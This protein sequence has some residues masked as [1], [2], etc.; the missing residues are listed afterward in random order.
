MATTSAAPKGLQLDQITIDPPAK[1]P[2]QPSVDP[3]TQR[4]LYAEADAR[5]AAQSGV[6]RK[7]DPHNPVDK[8]L[9]PAWFH[10]Y[11]G[12]LAEYGSG[13][14]HWTTDHLP[15]T[16]AIADAHDATTAAQRRLDL[17]TTPGEP[18]S[19]LSYHNAALDKALVASAAASKKAGAM[20]P[21]Q[22]PQLPALLENAKQTM[23]D[24]WAGLTG[25][26]TPADA[27]TFMQTQS[28]PAHAQAVAAV[29]PTSQDA[30]AVP[31]PSAKPDEA[32]ASSRGKKWTIGEGVALAGVAA[33]GVGII[34]SA[35][36]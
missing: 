9:I 6:T 34:A 29:A 36:R 8:H 25:Q 17:A 1:T 5:F 21:G 32:S 33:I 24:A 15:V 13:K 18:I 23:T 4:K 19:E 26:A 27:I 3:D 10:V 12:V 20:M 7:L 22:H 14:I 16:K 2:A 30:A 28:A 31:A 35:R 11:Q